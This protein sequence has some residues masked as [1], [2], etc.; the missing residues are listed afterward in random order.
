M[1]IKSI[2][3]GIGQIKGKTILLRTDFNVPLRSGKI[4]DEK[5]IIDSLPTIRF[6]LRYNCKLVIGTHLGRPG[7]KRLKKYSTKPVAK[8]LNEIL[9]GKKIKFIDE[10]SGPKA[11][12]EAEKLKP[13]KILFLENL[14]FKKEE[15]SNSKKFASELSRLADI[16]INDSFSVDHR[17]HASLNAIRGFLP[18]FHGLLVEKEIK[19]LDKIKRPKKPLIVVL[20]GAKIN[21]KINLIDEL[22]PKAKHIL[23]GGALANN[24][25]KARGFEVGKSLID[26]ESLNF[27]KR[28]KS[29]KIVL[30]ID[31]IVS[32]KI[33]GGQTKL[34]GI[35]EVKKK[36]IIL[37]IGPETIK[38]Y[39][40]LI[41]KGKSIIWN[42][43]MGFFEEEHFKHGTTV[44]AQVIAT[45]SDEKAFTVVGGG[46]TIE[47]LKIT[48]MEDYINWVSTGGGA[49]L[50]YLGGEKMPGL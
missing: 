43:P 48:K 12:K 31:L 33:K 16:Y 22:L 49:M 26:E 29:K 30:P 17:K 27:A 47:A 40:G 19:N 45:R 18:S 21:T 38:L 4:E 3:E 5:K 25:F 14:R 24:F 37:D 13:G 8:R 42:G 2:K 34:K 20:G 6:L 9:G 1:K 32:T 15:R 46:E 35:R 39:A 7:G 10:I 41:K 36:D 50:T 23:I 44:L 28:L 11:E